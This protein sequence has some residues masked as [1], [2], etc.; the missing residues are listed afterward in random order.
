MRDTTHPRILII[1]HGHPSFSKG[2]A[3]VA[4]YNLFKEYKKVHP[5]KVLFLA[6]HG[7]TGSETY[8]L[9]QLEKDEFLFYSNTQDYFT[10]TQ[11]QK[12]VLWKE[13]KSLIEKFQPDVVHFHHFIHIGVE[14]IRVV[15]NLSSAPKIFLTLHEY[16]AICNHN[17]QMV[18]T[19]ESK[20]LCYKS[21]PL[22]CHNCFTATSS[23]DFLLREYFL[24]SYFEI[25]D[26]FI[27]PSRFLKQRY[28]DWGIA[29]EKITVIENGQEPVSTV[30]S[31]DL[32][33]KEYKIRFGYF[34]QLNPYK[35]IDVLLNAFK[36]LPKSVKKQVRLDI[37]G[38]NLEIQ[39]PEFIAKIKQLLTEN[40]AV[41]TSHGSYESNELPSLLNQ[42]DCVIV[43]SI[44]WENSPMVI[45]EAFMYKRPVVCSNIGGM[46]EKVEDGVT[47][48][49]FLARKPES[50]KEKIIA[51]CNDRNLLMQM[52]QNIKSPL[53][54]QECAKE[55]L[56]LYHYTDKQEKKRLAEAA[57]R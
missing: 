46:E 4:A 12:E 21:S 13:V 2:G 5:G 16:S 53:S 14:L 50:L 55:H 45:Q 38:A 57:A 32:T 51:L 24:K 26:H 18:K 29:A 27:S 8:P 7:K 37:F 1:S 31:R 47:G 23:G 11:P 54:I 15:K 52:A 6:R 19:G 3:E 9:A 33:D 36:L 43:P 10:H 35:G 30:I 25:I 34:G 56:E 44:W 17:G 40:K 22:E 28:V 39:T 41:V 42:V 20:Q 49:H 48:V